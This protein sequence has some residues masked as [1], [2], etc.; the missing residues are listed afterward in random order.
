MKSSLLVMS[1]M[2]FIGSIAVGIADVQGQESKAVL[3]AS[4][5]VY[6]NYIWRGSRFG[7]GPHIQPTV[8]VETGGLTLGV[9]GSFDFNGYSEA[10]PY[11]SYSFPFGLSFGM[12]DYYYP[13]LSFFETSTANGSH[14]FELN[15]GYTVK[16]LSLSANYILNEAGG[17]GSTGGDVYFQV[18]Y[19][20]SSVNIFAGAGNG[21]HTSD[22]EF[23]FCNIGIG[24]VKTI[25]ITDKFSLPLTGQVIL[26]PEKEQLYLA[27]GFSF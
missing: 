14:A 25:E 22:G 6:S 10:D 13:G 26:N 11:I 18:G 4:A 3:S 9:W 17:A 15:G 2:V 5:D 1:G 8:K 21:W 12:T 27:V 7:Q 20:F 24:T 19:S 23:N 16:G